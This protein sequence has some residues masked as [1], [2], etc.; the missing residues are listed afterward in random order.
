MCVNFPHLFCVMQH[1][2]LCLTNSL[3]KT[4]VVGIECM[5][6]YNFEFNCLIAYIISIFNSILIFIAVLLLLQS[7][8]CRLGMN[9]GSSHLKHVFPVQCE[10]SRWRV[11]THGHH[12]RHKDQGSNHCCRQQPG[13]VE[14]CRHKA[15]LGRSSRLMQRGCAITLQ[16]CCLILDEEFGWASQI[17]DVHC[18]SS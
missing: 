7:W 15:P 16:H 10:D 11:G 3:S 4:L 5:L 8:I 1:L 13:C 6:L 9:K 2:R 12:S 17:A 14:T 18:V